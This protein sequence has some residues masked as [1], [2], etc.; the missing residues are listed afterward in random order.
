MIML[1]LDRVGLGEFEKFKLD[2]L[3]ND[4][5]NLVYVIISFNIIIGFF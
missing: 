4:V 1:G 3:F 5:Y 2:V